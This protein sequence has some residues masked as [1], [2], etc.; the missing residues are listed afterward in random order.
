VAKTTHTAH[1]EWEKTYSTY[2]SLTQKLEHARPQDRDALER[3]IAE[4]EDDLLDTP[5]PHATALLRK[6]ELLFEGDLHGLDRASEER[7]LVIEDLIS[8]IDAHHQLLG[9]V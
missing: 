7:R 4:I 8:L 2:L 6:L 5:A 1:I 9:T 3:K